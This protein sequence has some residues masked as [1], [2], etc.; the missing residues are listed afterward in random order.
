MQLVNSSNHFIAIM[1]EQFGNISLQSFLCKSIGQV[2]LFNRH[3]SLKY[4]EKNYRHYAFAFL[5]SVYA[6]VFFV[7]NVSYSFSTENCFYVC[8]ANMHM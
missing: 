1:F 3:T 8:L 7:A 6:L 5:F 2:P 4:F